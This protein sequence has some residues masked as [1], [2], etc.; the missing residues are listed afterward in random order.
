MGRGKRLTNSK[1]YLISDYNATS[2][3]VKTI[4]FM[5]DQSINVINTYLHNP[6]EYKYIKHPRRY[7]NIYAHMKRRIMRMARC[8]GKSASHIRNILK[9]DVTTHQV[10]Q[11]LSEDTRLKQTKCNMTLPLSHKHRANFAKFTHRCISIGVLQKYV[12]F[13]D[14]KKF[15]LDRSDGCQKL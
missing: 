15:N 11:I 1:C 5:M 7:P 3:K 10:Q 4:S 2:I 8:T 14:K 9:L 13:S 12:L 6:I